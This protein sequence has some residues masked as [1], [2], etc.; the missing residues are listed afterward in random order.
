MRQR[1]DNATRE[2]CRELAARTFVV[3]LEGLDGVGKTTTARLLA[4]KLGVQ[5]LRTPPCDMELARFDVLREPSSLARYLYYW[6][7]VVRVSELLVDMRGVVIVDRYIGSV[8]AMHAP[9]RHGMDAKLAA[10]AT[11][12]D[13][14]IILDASEE[15]RTRRISQR[16]TQ[17]DPYES[18]LSEPLFR[19]I[20]R[21][22]LERAPKAVS[23]S[24]DTLNPAEVAEQCA[25]IIHSRKE[26][27]D[28]ATF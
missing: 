14:S 24:T 10:T 26:K 21:S 2:G 4:E 9:F 23:L 19:S 13:L 7:S 25:I 28:V 5:T 17:M 27:R 8:W 6:A 20:V 16:G 1:R 12:P 22:S 11:S 15:V 3:A 18:L